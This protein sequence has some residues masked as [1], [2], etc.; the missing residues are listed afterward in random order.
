MFR[1]IEIDFY[2]YTLKKKKKDKNW[3]IEGGSWERRISTGLYGI[4]SIYNSVD[5]IK[6]P[7]SEFLVKAFLWQDALGDNFFVPVLPPMACTFL[8]GELV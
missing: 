3:R 7:A 8:T 2:K 5:C 4:I 1:N 6:V